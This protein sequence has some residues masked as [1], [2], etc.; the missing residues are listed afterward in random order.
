MSRAKRTLNLTWAAEGPV[1]GTGGLTPLLA[2]FRTD[3]P[4]DVDPFN[5]EEADELAWDVRTKT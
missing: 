1:P 4:P 5:G 3:D 2:D